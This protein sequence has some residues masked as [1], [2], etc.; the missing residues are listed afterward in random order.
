MIKT[1]LLKKNVELAK[2]K[3]VNDPMLERGFSLAYRKYAANKNI[4]EETNTLMSTF[5]QG[6]YD[7]PVEAIDEAIDESSFMFEFEV[8]QSAQPRFKQLECIK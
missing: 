5:L 6:V 4:I 2:I 7:F 1:E 8:M 3:E